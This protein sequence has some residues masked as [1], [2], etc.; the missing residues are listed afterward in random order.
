MCEVL[1]S[2]ADNTIYP[3]LGGVLFHARSGVP[4]L[5]VAPLRV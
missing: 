4:G 5:A 3:E 2:T 1:I